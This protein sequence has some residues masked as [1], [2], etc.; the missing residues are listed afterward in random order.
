MMGSTCR[1]WV[2]EAMDQVKKSCVKIQVYLQVQQE[3]Y[4]FQCI[5]F[6]KYY[7]LSKL[8]EGVYKKFLKN[9]AKMKEAKPDFGVSMAIL[10][11]YFAMS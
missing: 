6:F 9:R 5:Y 7:Q 3:V 1:Q 2:D 11:L 8:G 10:T 4:Q